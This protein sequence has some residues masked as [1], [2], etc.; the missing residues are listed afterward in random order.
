MNFGWEKLYD[1]QKE[2]N[3]KLIFFL[4]S[5]VPSFLSKSNRLTLVY[6]LHFQQNYF[7]INSVFSNLVNI[8]LVSCFLSLSLS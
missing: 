7:S 1:Y 8:F 3:H 6:S 5:F 2:K 4:L